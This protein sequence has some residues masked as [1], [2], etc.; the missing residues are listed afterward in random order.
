MV[1]GFAGVRMFTTTR[2]S[3]KRGLYT[4]NVTEILA[5]WS[6]SAAE[7]VSDADRQIQ[8]CKPATND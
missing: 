5:L 6:L 1:I 2:R 7:R 8:V 4:E 3:V